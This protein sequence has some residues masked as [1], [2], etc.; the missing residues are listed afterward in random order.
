MFESGDEYGIDSSTIAVFSYLSPNLGNHA[1]NG[2]VLTKF[3]TGGYNT[4]SGG[5]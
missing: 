4:A 2:T 1:Q 5:N 3:L